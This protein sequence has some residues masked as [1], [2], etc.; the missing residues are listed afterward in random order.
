[1]TGR[2][3]EL[4]RFRSRLIVVPAA[5]VLDAG[6]RSPSAA[7]RALGAN[8]AVT[9]S[10]HDAGSD[11]LVTI[12]VSDTAAVRQ[13]RG[14]TRRFSAANFAPESIVEALARLL[15]LEL[16][17]DDARAWR[18]TASAVPAAGVLF[19]QAQGATPYEQARSALERIDQQA[20]LERAIDLFNKAVD[21]TRGMPPLMPDS[22]TR[23]CGCSG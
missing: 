20:S 12:G 16:A 17:P 10:V 21:G 18:E 15:D 9:I 19:A 22:P 4:Q 1:M 8:L 6:A 14:D 13:L 23:A 7:R 5:E 11:R 2:V 3:A